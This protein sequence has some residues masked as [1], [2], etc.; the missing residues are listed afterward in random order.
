MR[1]RIDRLIAN[2]AKEDIKKIR[3]FTNTRNRNLFTIIN[4]I[5]LCK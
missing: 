3:K 2:F 4:S 5:R 1:I